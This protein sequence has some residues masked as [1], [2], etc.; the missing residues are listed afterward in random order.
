MPPRTSKEFVTASPDYI[1]VRHVKRG[2]REKAPGVAAA[3]AL[4]QAAVWEFGAGP[5]ADPRPRGPGTGTCSLTPGK[6]WL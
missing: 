2:E 6:R 4:E 3:A 5:T 1:H